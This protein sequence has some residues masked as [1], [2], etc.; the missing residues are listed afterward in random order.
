MGSWKE[1][2]SVG[3]EMWLPGLVTPLVTEQ[4]V[5]VKSLFLVCM[6]EKVGTSIA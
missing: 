5:T 4:E 1:H 3:P 2:R 6:Q